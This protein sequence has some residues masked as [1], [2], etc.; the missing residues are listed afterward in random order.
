MLH[1]SNVS[2]RLRE[3][4]L[5]YLIAA[6]IGVMTMTSSSADTRQ[7]ARDILQLLLNAPRLTKY[8]HFDLRPERAPLN[9]VNLTPL[10]IGN[11][12]LTAAG[13]K[14]LISTERNQ[15]AIEITTF[16]ITGDSAAIGFTFRVEGVIGEATFKRVQG[17]WSLDKF[18]AAER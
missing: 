10:D 1:P 8:Y 2:V 11:P 12:E 9:V 4:V 17:T 15:R 16:K 5:R 7:D 18:S 3:I 14:V 6:A 13:Q